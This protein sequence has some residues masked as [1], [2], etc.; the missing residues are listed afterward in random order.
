MSKF[1]AR[2][3]SSIYNLRIFHNWVKREMINQS[4]KY[5]EDNYNINN[6]KVLDLSC[7]KF[8]D[9]NKYFDNGI[10]YVIG[11][12]IDAISINEAKKRYSQLINQ[13]KMKNVQ[14]LPVYKFYVMDLSDPNSLEK[15]KRILNDEKF[16]IVSCQFAIHYFFKSQD[17]LNTFMTIVSSYINKNAFFIGVTMNGNKIKQLFAKNDVIENDIFKIENNTNKFEMANSVYNNKYSVNLGDQNDTE[18]YFAGNTSEEYLVDINELKK[19]CKKFGLMAILMTDFEDWYYK[20]GK[21]ILT[22]NEKEFSFLNFSF[23]FM[24]NKT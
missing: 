15:I 5:L 6:I 11:F 10:M 4:A 23:I 21:D 20:F 16:D 7:G 19:V 14:K 8:G 18:H 17:T 9:M 24:P 12:D 22:K 1:K 2:K 13:L 3:E